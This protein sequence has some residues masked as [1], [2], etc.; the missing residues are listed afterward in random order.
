MVNRYETNTPG[1]A[2]TLYIADRGIRRV[3]YETKGFKTAT[4]L[5]AACRSNNLIYVND[6]SDHDFALKEKYFID[7]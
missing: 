4:R 7:E 2:R 6:D 1:I 3:P 5:S